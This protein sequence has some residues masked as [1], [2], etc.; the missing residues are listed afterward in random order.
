MKS[1]VVF[2]IEVEEVQKYYELLINEDFD[3]K[4]KDIDVNFKLDSNNILV[5]IN[6][7]SFIDTKI[8]V[9]SVMKSLEVI[10]KTFDI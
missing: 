4:T 10:E 9:S 6:A 1:S 2:K 8:G 7:S 5:T 3:F